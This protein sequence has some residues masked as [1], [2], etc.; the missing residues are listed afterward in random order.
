MYINKVKRVTPQ[1]ATAGCVQSKKIVLLNQNV[2]KGLDL[3]NSTVDGIAGPNYRKAVAGG[4]K[5][6][7]QGA[8]DQKGCLSLLERNKL[9]ALASAPER[10]RT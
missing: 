1:I 8:D 7:G 10:A 5:L 3:Y 6:L 9:M 4:E 2:L